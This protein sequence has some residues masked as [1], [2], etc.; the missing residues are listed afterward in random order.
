ME[1]VAGEAAEI[2]SNGGSES[3]VKMTSTTTGQAP[4]LTVSA[5]FKE[6]GGK[7]SSR[8][9]P[10]RP[11]FDTDN[12]FITLLHGSDPV[13]VE[14]NRLENE[15]RDKDRELGEAQAEIKALRMSERQREKAVE[16]VD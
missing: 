14:L 8:R 10:V 3:P 6:S 7:S 4:T 1:E 16:E 12:E 11:S 5:T 13:K 2:G 9:R 15:V